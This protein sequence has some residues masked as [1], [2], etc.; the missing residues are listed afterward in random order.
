MVD[1]FVTAA[2][3]DAVLSDCLGV[4]TSYFSDGEPAEMSVLDLVDG[5]LTPFVERYGERAVTEF[6]K[7]FADAATLAEM[8][9]T[10]ARTQVM[11]ADRIEEYQD[12]A[13]KIQRHLDDENVEVDLDT[14][15]ESW[16]ETSTTHVHDEHRLVM[17]ETGQMHFWNNVTHKIELNT[18]DKLLIPMSRLHGSTVL[19]GE[20]TYHQPIIPEDIFRRFD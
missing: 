8:W 18:G 16:E 19:S 5:L 10:D 3:F 7:G 13:E 12:K 9:N 6:H 11:W 14:F 4:D 15:V 17:I 20:C 2:R 1:E